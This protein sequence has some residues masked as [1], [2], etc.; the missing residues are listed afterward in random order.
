MEQVCVWTR[1]SIASRSDESGFSR[2]CSRVLVDSFTN[3]LND[4]VTSNGLVER[5]NK[6]DFKKL[7]GGVLANPV[8]VEDSQGTT[9]SS[10]TFLCNALSGTLE[11]QLINTMSLWFTISATFR[12]WAFTSSTLDSHSV[13]NV[14]L[15]GT[16]SQTTS[17]VWTSGSRGPVNCRELSV[18]PTTNSNEEA[19]N[20]ALLLPVDLLHIFVGAHF[21]SLSYRAVNLTAQNLKRKSKVILL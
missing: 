17:L 4:W 12:N 3:P 1:A 10:S 19:H 21:E 8:R 7:V 14:S 16:V 5:I 15:F 11:F 18:L 20:I 13:D 9:L 2:L 6:N